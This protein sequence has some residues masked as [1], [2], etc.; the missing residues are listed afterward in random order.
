MD[1]TLLCTGRLFDDH[2]AVPF[3]LQMTAVSSRR[4]LLLVAQGSGVLAYDIAHCA[5]LPLLRARL[6]RA[7]LEQ[8]NDEINAIALGELHGAEALVA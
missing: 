4:R 6:R 2:A 1:V 7:V 5:H 3:K 8:P